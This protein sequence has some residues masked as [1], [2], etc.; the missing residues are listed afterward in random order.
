MAAVNVVNGELIAVKVE[1]V[2]GSGTYAASCLINSTRGLEASSSAV[3]S[4]VPDCDDPSLPSVVYR[5]KDALTWQI[6]GEGILDVTSIDK[7]DD[8]HVSKDSKS[9][10][11]EIQKTG[12]FVWTGNFHLT[13]FS[14]S[15]TRK[16]KA[17]AS[18][19]LMSDGPVTRT[20]YV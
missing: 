10:K 15:G 5:E 8:W 14:I 20:A 17:T 9:V 4:P 2:D 18:V 19:T 16:E 6:T 7:W 1:W 11:V 13:Q 3:E 12:G